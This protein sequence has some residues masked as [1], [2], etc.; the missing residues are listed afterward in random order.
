[1][2]PKEK[3]QKKYNESVAQEK[4]AG[5]VEEKARKLFSFRR[6]TN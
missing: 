4:T 5:M 3:A 2:F 6:L 1:V